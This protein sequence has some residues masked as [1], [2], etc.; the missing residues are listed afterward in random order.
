MYRE[1][2]LDWRQIKWI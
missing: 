1:M 2:H